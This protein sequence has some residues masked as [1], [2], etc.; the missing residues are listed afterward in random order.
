MTA[1]TLPTTRLIKR[2][3]YDLKQAISKN[4]FVGLWRLMEGYR[5]F[6]FGAIVS[7]GLSALAKSLTLVLLSYFVD[8]VLI[9]DDMLSIVPFVALGFVALAL[10]EGGFRFLSGT[11]AAQ[12]AEGV[13]LRL[14]NYLFDQMQRL[15]FTYHDKNPTGDLLQRCTSDVDAVRRFF[16]DQG[17]EI[18]RITLLFLVNFIA[19]A[20]MNWQLALFSS[21]VI[22]IVVII[23]LFFFKR[24]S[25][26]YEAYQ[27]QEAKLSTRLQENLTGV[28]VVKAFARQ[29][30]EIGRF[31]SENFE[32]FRRGRRMLI[33]HALFWPTLDILTGLQL[34]GCYLVGALLVIDN[35]MSIGEYLAYAGMVVYIIFP[36]RNLGR[37]IVQMS[38]GL[39]SFDRVMEVIREEREP[40][41]E[42]EAAPVE[43]LVGHVV[44]EDVT[45]EYEKD[46]PVLNH[47]SFEA[48]PGQVIALMGSTGSGKTS[49]V[50]LLPR[51][52]EVTQGRILLDGVDL[53]EYPRDFL[54][55]SIGIVEQEPF[56]FSRTIRENITYSV[57]RDVT[58]EELFRATKAAAIHH[59]IE[60]FPEGY[61][62]LVGERGVTLS[63]GQKQRVAVA[64]T[65]LKNPRILIMDDATSSVDTETEAAIRTALK[66][67]LPGRT[68]FII[69]HRVQTVMSADLIVVFDKG[70]IVQMGTH[71]ELLR[72]ETG[73]YRRIYDMQSRIDEELEKELAGE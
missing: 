72:D 67:L 60:G 55:R 40:L 54:R 66:E 30:H 7:Q 56:L 9:R 11:W 20:T 37:V 1:S 47:V 5:P 35:R 26:R 23:S 24:V 16:V 61:K 49:L 21:I 28:R 18:G 52:Y 15:S 73:I 63:G 45:F 59:V 3:D 38:T 39:V 34:I 17:A 31:E 64:R 69:A 48:K 57:G 43:N 71:H 68:S 65:L 12:T 25:D 4:R 2:P 36:M 32:H 58:D 6:Y 44:F 50:G 22:P 62:T 33:M 53:R 13:A 14:R 27:E 46:T 42:G 29:E 51:F 19:I 70:V 8:K 10:F 41:R